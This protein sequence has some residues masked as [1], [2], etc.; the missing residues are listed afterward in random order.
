MSITIISPGLTESKYRQMMPPPGEFKNKVQR[1][2]GEGHD[3]TSLNI[4][5]VNVISQHNRIF[6][7]SQKFGYT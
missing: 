4:D 7:C 6:Y 1:E 3:E 5:L 2:E